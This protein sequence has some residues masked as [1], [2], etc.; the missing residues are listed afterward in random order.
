MSERERH[1]PRAFQ[2]SLHFLGFRVFPGMPL[3]RG[4]TNRCFC[5]H[6]LREWLGFTGGCGEG[7]RPG[8]L[9]ELIQHL[10]HT[11]AIRVNGLP[12]ALRGH[13]ASAPHCVRPLYSHPGICDTPCT[14]PAACC[15]WQSRGRCSDSPR[16]A[17]VPSLGHA[18]AVCSPRAGAARCMS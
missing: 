11:G 18:W 6:H 1:A 3:A 4:K 12:Q 13:R 8:L 2:T 16:L 5:V 14:K 17:Q 7:W 9:S 15:C 10:G